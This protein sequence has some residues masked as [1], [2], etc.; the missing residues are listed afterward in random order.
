[1]TEKRFASIGSYQIRDIE[2]NRTYDNIDDIK[3]VMN[4]LHNENEQLREELNIPT[5]PHIV[6]DRKELNKLIHQ[7]AMI[8]HDLLKENKQLKQSNR[9]TLREFEKGVNKVQKLANENEQ[10]KQQ[11]NDLRVGVLD[12]IHEAE[13]IQCSC[14]PC[15]VEEC[16]KK[17]IE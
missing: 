16:V 1:M 7:L 2:M 13:E 17:V 11:I 8:N 14:N 6:L 5:D 3:E 12:S 9:A 4:E 15:V 10:L